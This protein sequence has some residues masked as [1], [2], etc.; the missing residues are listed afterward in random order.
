[1]VKLDSLFPLILK[2]LLLYILTG[3]GCFSGCD[4]SDIQ[5]N[6]RDFECVEVWSVKLSLALF[7]ILVKLTSEL[8]EAQGSCD[9]SSKLCLWKSILRHGLQF[10][11][12]TLLPELRYLWITLK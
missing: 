1:M 2:S 3:D 8:S 10:S 4:N 7:V 6:L 12:Q 5:Q 9:I 11:T